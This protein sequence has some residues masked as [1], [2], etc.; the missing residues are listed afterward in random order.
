MRRRLDLAASL[1]GRPRFLYLDEPTTG[2]DPRSR[3]QLWGLIKE[4]VASGTTVLLTTQYL[5]EADHLADG[6]VVVDHGKVIAQGTADELK[7]K[8]G[9]QVVEVQPAAR[10]DVQEVVNVLEGL[11][12]S[13]AQVDNSDGLVTVAVTD[14]AV[15]G[16]AVVRLKQAGV[17]I[18]HMALRRASLDEVF[19]A[20]T[21]H[22]AEEA[23]DEDGGG[24]PSDQRAPELERSVR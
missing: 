22:P 13:E 5:D 20:L 21:G 8:V 16:D 7:A 19:L 2:L 15:L 4:L 11:S 9:G 10:S 12:G 1:V 17:T 24:R 18:A 3:H 14:S 6:I 23:R